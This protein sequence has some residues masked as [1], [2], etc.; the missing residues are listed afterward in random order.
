MDHSEV[1]K[2]S[3]MLQHFCQIGDH[4]DK[5]FAADASL[6]AK[7]VEAEGVRGSRQDFK[8]ISGSC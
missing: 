7:F 6:E 5:G 3:T 4:S 8:N 1:R 2:T